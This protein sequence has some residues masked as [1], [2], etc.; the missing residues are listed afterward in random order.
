MLNAGVLEPVVIAGPTGVGKSRLALGLAE[1]LGGEIVNYDSVQIYKGFDVGSAK[2]SATERALVPHHLY[3][4][5]EADEHFDAHAYA[6]L[7]RAVC[8]EI[9]ARG[10]PPLL[11]GGTFFYLRAFLTGLPE[12]P[13]R[14][15]TV[16]TRLR[17][18]LA[19][20]R[21]RQRLHR[22][23]ARVDPASASRIA[24]ADRHRIERALEVFLTSGSPIS[25]R[26]PPVAEG[27]AIP[28][29]KLALT[30]PRDQLSKILDDR[31][32]AMYRGGLVEET[33]RLLARHSY[34]CRPF[35]AIGYKEAARLLMN[36]I[37]LEEA[38]RETR[39]RTRAYAKRQLTWLR[40]EHNVHW[41]DAAAN[42]REVLRTAIS[43]VQKKI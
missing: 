16:R 18:L 21:G 30:L 22:W 39:R 42:P 5:I 41:I 43:V 38:M 24:P 26:Q 7:A 14:D 13:A 28:H 4:I 29:V 25:E 31:V 9:Q 23:L 15:E 6:G 11:V 35:A 32:E 17:R 2:P 8:S 3:D 36:E 33:R 37:N 1:E 19:T 12:L 10:H 20:P 40:G 27:P 34:Q